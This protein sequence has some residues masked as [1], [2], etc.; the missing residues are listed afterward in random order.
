M[1]HPRFTKRYRDN[2]IALVKLTQPVEISNL[3]R[4]ICLREEKEENYVGKK[5]FIT[6]W[7]QNADRKY[8]MKLQEAEVSLFS[9]PFSAFFS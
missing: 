9:Y 5:C 7:G 6:G 3:V 2:D 4:P 8:S 1:R